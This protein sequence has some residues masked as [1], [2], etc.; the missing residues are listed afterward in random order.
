MPLLTRSR[1]AIVNVLSLAAVANFPFDRT[2][3]I[4]KDG[5]AV[6]VFQPPGDTD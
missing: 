1:G 3:S 5:R 4:S 6:P 2:Y